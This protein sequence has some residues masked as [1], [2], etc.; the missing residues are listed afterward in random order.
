MSRRS[1][2][3]DILEDPKA[4]QGK[5]L[6]FLA[7]M[8]RKILTELK[9][10]PNSPHGVD[11]DQFKTLVERW[12]SKLEET[13]TASAV[14]SLRNNTVKTLADDRITW[15]TISRAL[16]MLACSGKF[17]KIR[18]VFQFY[19]NEKDYQEIG[20]NY[21]TSDA[22]QRVET[23]RYVAPVHKLS[24]GHFAYI[25]GR[26]ELEGFNNCPWNG[27]KVTYIGPMNLPMSANIFDQY[28][29]TDTGLV[30]ENHPDQPDWVF[31]EDNDA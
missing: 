11:A 29:E 13:K 17:F 30:R 19:W 22:E 1:P 26:Y 4:A 3:Q 7:L 2:M 10:S 20:M 18:I 25:G 21:M 23:P 6:N 27:R 15:Q 31:L 5:S 28:R 8:W 14:A 16:D 12:R 9:F 24:P